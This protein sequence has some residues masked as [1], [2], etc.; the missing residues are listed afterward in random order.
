MPMHL[1]LKSTANAK[2]EEQVVD[3]SPG[4]GSS[5]GCEDGE[6]VSVGSQSSGATG[7]VNHQQRQRQEKVL[8]PTQR[9]RWSGSS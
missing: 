7:G 4:K 5:G 2:L 3:I 6:A 1:D 9:M 8:Q